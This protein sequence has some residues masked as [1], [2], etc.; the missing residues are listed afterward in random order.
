M[1]VDL[2]AYEKKLNKEGYT[3]IAGVDEAGRGPLV[4]PVVAGAVILPQNYKLEGL[5]DS[6][7]LS[8]KKRNLFYDIIKRDAISVGVGIVSAKEID[9][10]YFRGL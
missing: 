7:Q 8:E 4:G 1:A 9:D 6:K 3:L 10:K 5:N 2:L